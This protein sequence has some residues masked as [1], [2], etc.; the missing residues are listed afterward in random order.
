[1][2]TNAVQFM[3][4]KKVVVIGAGPAGLSAAYALAKEGVEVEVFEA[5]PYIGGM[6]RSFDLWNQRVDLGPHRFFST[7]PTVNGFFAELVEQDYTVVNRLTRIYYGNK[8]FF[9]PL[10]L[11]NVIRNLRFTTI[12]RVLFDYMVQRIRPIKN[13]KSF[14]EWVTNRFGK[15]LYS[16]F[17][18]NYTEKLWGID[19]SDIDVDWA[20]QRI[21]TLS[22]FGAIKN[23]MVGGR[24][25]K[26]KTLVDQFHYPKSGTGTLYERAAQKVQEFGGKVHLSQPVKRL[27]VEGKN[28]KG[29]ELVDGTIVNADEVISTM[30]MTKLVAGL[31]ECPIDVKKATDALF[32]RNTILVYLNCNSQEL[33]EDN[34]IYVHSADVKLGRITNFRNWCPSLN[35]DE[36]S[37]I[38]C[39]EYWAFDNDEI[40]SAD[41]KVLG[42]LGSKELKT[43]GLIDDNLEILD[44]AVVRVPKCYPVYQTG[45]QKHLKVVESYLDT[46]NGLTVIGRYGAFKYN[47]QDHSILMGIL[48][49]KNSLGHSS[50]NLWE[51]NTDSEYQ[52]EGK[53]KDVLIQ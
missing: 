6:S 1:M 32:F 36:N 39:L 18:K 5:S 21:K 52:E 16:I 35:G 23:A 28:V 45:Y 10:K 47:N 43:L 40:W 26:H 13:P 31:D 27:V 29:I 44:T 50:T 25:N 17:F 51:I 34:W 19:A 22:L 24:N 2:F 12:V 11:G 33:F 7:D 37:T 48:A 46:Y 3:S 14:D 38:L 49:A 53:I 42:D 15:K 41:D 30:P 8:F 20:A 9:Y 4:K